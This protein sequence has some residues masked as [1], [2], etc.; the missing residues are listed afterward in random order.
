[1]LVPNAQSSLVAVDRLRDV[2]SSPMH[3]LIV[4]FQY[5]RPRSLAMRTGSSESSV[6]GGCP[7]VF[8]Q[9][10]LGLTRGPGY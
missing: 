8:C 4:G 1:M 9:A 6:R 7:Y 5:S 10:D 2:S 3:V